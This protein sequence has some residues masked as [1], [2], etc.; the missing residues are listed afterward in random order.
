MAIQNGKSRE[1]GTTGHT[2][3]RSG[4]QKRTIER[5]RH[6][7]AHKTKKLQLKT[8][9]PENP[10]PQG[11]QNEEVTIKNGKFR[12]PGTIGHTR[13]RSGN[14]KWKI[15]RTR[16]HRA[17]KTKKWQSKMD[18]PE[19]PTPQGT[20]DEEVAIKNGLSRNSGTTG[21]TRRRSGNKKRTIQRTRHHRAQKTKKWQSKTEI[22][23]N[24]APQ[25]TQDKE[26]AIKNG[27]SREPGTTGHTRRRSG[28]PKWKIQRT[29]HHR[30]HKTKKLQ[31]KTDNP[32]NSA[33]Q[34]TQDEEVA[35]K[36][37]KSREPGTTG[38]T[39]RRSG[40]KKR[41]IQ[42]TRHHRAHKTKKWQSKTDYPENPSPQGTQDKEVGI[43]NGQSR[44][45]GTTGHTRRRSGNKKRTIQRTR[46][47]RAHKTKKWQSKTENPENPAPQGNQKR[48]F[49]RTRHHR[50]H[51]TKKWQ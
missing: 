46:H 48:T 23:E 26:V 38:H 16:H 17:H 12:E 19:N 20:Q 11:T 29:R 10:A 22:P 47:H 37:G 25:G 31:L 49:Q 9:N 34:G 44:E 5:T 14:P 7:R 2:R 3:R 18:N 6:H 35:I 40:N 21:H 24:S 42:R 41:T 8:D 32:E 4:N 36:N 39:R 33:P 27:Q 13:R 51:K 28:N 30:A 15:Q 50:V 45:P 1:P 43:K